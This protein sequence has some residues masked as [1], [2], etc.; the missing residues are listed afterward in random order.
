MAKDLAAAGDTVAAVKGQLQCK[1][2]ELIEQRGYA[3]QLAA[4]SQQ[5]EKPT[6]PFDSTFLGSGAP[7]WPRP[8]P[9]AK[10]A[11]AP[12]Q[13][14][15]GGWPSQSETWGGAGWGGYADWTGADEWGGA[16]GWGGA[17]DWGYAGG[18]GGAGD[19]EGAA[20]GSAGYDVVL[21][22][23]VVRQAKIA[24]QQAVPRVPQM[25]RE[26]PGHK[27][28]GRYGSKSK[29]SQS[30]VAIWYNEYHLAR[31]AGL[32]MKV[33]E[34]ANPHP[35]KGGAKIVPPAGPF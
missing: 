18:G 21:D 32:N 13:T 16:S 10:P 7:P 12:Q 30:A 11:F 26:R 1:E 4:S 14:E 17:S 6:P 35:K 9:K 22:Q 25:W 34:D 2:E 31:K 20:S 8:D 23:E 27:D 29:S 15:L 28:G 5:Q 24:R 19:W 3:A 33:W